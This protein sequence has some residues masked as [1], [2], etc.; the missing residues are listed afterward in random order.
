MKVRLEICDCFNEDPPEATL[1][2]FDKLKEIAG[3][4]RFDWDSQGGK[5]KFVR[6]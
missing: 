1:K 5:F 2:E 3:R 6:A 4:V